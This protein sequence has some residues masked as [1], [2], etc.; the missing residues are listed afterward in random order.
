[1]DG[2]G[3]V[4]SEANQRMETTHSMKVRG[5]RRSGQKRERTK[6]KGARQGGR[7]QSRGDTQAL[8]FE[9]GER[10]PNKKKKKKIKT[11]SA[12]IRLLAPDFN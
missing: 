5:C 7:Q 11:K 10:E 1:M 12:S 3:T 2:N 4:N 9:I 6:G 8:G